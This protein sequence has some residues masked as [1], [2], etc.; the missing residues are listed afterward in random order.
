MPN[1]FLHLNIF[2]SFLFPRKISSFMTSLQTDMIDLTWLLPWCIILFALSLTKLNIDWA[3][4]TRAWGH[5]QAS[6]PLFSPSGTP[7]TP[8]QDSLLA[9]WGCFLE[10]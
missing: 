10:F 9:L 5:S 8:A 7:L 2:K 4:L 3:P 1:T 6:L